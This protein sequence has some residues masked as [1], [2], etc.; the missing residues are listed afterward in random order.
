MKRFRLA[1][2]FCALGFCLATASD[3][4]S[5]TDSPTTNQPRRANVTPVNAIDVSLTIKERN[6]LLT[7][8]VE[9]R[10]GSEAMAGKPTSEQ[11]RIEQRLHAYF[12][13]RRKARDAMEGPA[14]TIG[15]LATAKEQITIR[16]GSDGPRYEVRSK[17]GKTVL[18]KDLTDAQLQAFS[19][20]LH[21]FVNTAYAGKSSRKGVVIDARL[22]PTSNK[23]TQSGA[24]WMAD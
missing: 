6:R 5:P 11:K 22:Y 19:P 2:T 8:L 18:A 15:H 21:K 20:K 3:D 14:P 9:L 10:H 16:A 12:A 13:A 17:D 23:S 24:I 1:S 7:R 4:A